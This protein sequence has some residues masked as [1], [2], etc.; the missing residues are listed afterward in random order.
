M[1]TK[2]SSLN[3]I[4]NNTT[5]IIITFNANIHLAL[6]THAFHLRPHFNQTNASLLFSLMLTNQEIQL[7]VSTDPYNILNILLCTV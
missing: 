7:T 3:N 4:F 2:K 5:L 1:F 6:K